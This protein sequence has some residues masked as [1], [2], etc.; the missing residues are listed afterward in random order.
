MRF[1]IQGHPNIQSIHKNTVEF[2]KDDY[3][4]K[5]GDCIL[6]INA[7]FSLKKL[8]KLAKRTNKVKVI[9]SIDN[10]S[11]FFTAQTNPDF[12]DSHEL[13][14]RKSSFLSKRTFG[15]CANKAAVDIDRR[16]VEK[17]KDKDSE[18]V[19]KIVEAENE[20]AS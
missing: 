15:I 9:I 1:T 5:R 2:T 12:D 17:L 4:T 10:F 18:A 8:T 6:G 20:K 16:I 13:V 14:I 19:V 3:V 7:D 11:D